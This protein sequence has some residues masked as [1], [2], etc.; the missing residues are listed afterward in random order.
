MKEILPKVLRKHQCQAAL[1]SCLCQA[2]G[3]YLYFHVNYAYVHIHSLSPE[4]T[5]PQV[6]LICKS[7]MK[8][9]PETIL[10]KPETEKNKL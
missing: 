6:V 10:E 8:L 7:A 9:H 2:Q 4:Q 5:A 1:F 3:K